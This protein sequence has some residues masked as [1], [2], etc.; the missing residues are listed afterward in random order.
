MCKVLKLLEVDDSNICGTDRVTTINVTY[1]R[2]TSGLDT[3]FFEQF[4]KIEIVI[5]LAF[6]PTPCGALAWEDTE[7]I[8]YVLF[9]LFTFA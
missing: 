3:P 6:R 5:G 8:L 2:I 4:Q 1:R 7:S 9:I